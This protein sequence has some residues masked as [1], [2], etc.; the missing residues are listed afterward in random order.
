MAAQEGHAEVVQH[1]LAHGAE[2]NQVHPTNGA[3]ALLIAS[4][5]GH[6][7]VVQYL[8]A[9]GAGRSISAKAFTSMFAAQQRSHA[10]VVLLLRGGL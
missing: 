3:F 6:A 5:K 2:V 10:A 9:H 1:L 4:E 8:L 7:E